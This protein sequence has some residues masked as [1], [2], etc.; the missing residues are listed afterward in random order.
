MHKNLVLTL[1]GQDNIGIVEHVTNIILKYNGNIT[2]SKMARLGGEFAMLMQ[3]SV[4]KES[5]TTIEKALTKLQD[6]GYQI[7]YKETSD[8]SS[9]K[10]IGWLPYEIM[11]TGADHEGIINQV[12]AKIA[13]NGMNIESIDTKTSLAPMSGTALFSM[14]AIVLAPPKKTIHRWAE[15]LDEVADEMNVDIEIFNYKG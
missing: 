5:F 11:V 6:E 14:T 1:I 2:E 15:E 7:Y 3:I 8:E 4:S 10:F 9:Q 13:K 12:T